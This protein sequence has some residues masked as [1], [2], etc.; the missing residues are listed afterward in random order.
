MP[1][2]GTDPKVTPARRPEDPQPG[3]VL[4]RSGSKIAFAGDEA[5]VA[6]LRRGLPAAKAAFFDTYHE[7]SRSILLHVLGRDAE[8]DD[9]LHDVF[10]N[11]FRSVSSVRDPSALK[12]WLSRVTVFTARRVLR[13]RRRRAWLRLFVNDEQEEL[14]EPVSIENAHATYAVRVVYTLLA[15]LSADEQ[16]VFGLY[17]VDGRSLSEIA[18]LTGVSLATVK[19]RMNRARTNFLRE[20][21]GHSMLSDWIREVPNES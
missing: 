15:R 14:H 9:V 19:R 4:A 2:A 11:A 12:A 13:S 16:L 1:R 8:L 7:V 10:V 3:A 18:E 21:G 20:A 6:G 17:Y 5:L